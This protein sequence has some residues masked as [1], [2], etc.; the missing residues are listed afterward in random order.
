[1]RIVL[2]AVVAAGCGAQPFGAND[3]VELASELSAASDL[4]N[5]TAQ[6]PGNNIPI[7]AT[8]PCTNGSIRIVGQLVG[9]P[10]AG[11]YSIDAMT[12]ISG[13]V[14][15]SGY[16]VDAGPALATGGSLEVGPGG[17]GVE[18]SQ[19]T[20]R[21]TYPLASSDCKVDVSVLIA[22]APPHVGGAICGNAIDLDE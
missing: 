14:L 20:F 8:E 5:S 3:A 19:T 1:M 11:T 16:A 10:D 17:V 4:A 22:D 12:T 15:S 18:M 13:C 2:V 7:D 9:D 21:G 6:Q